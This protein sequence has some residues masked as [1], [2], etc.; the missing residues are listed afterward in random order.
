MVT[1]V[2]CVRSGSAAFK[3]CPKC[4]FFHNPVLVVKRQAVR[5]SEYDMISSIKMCKI[6][7]KI[8]PNKLYKYIILYN[9]IDVILFF[10]SYNEE[11][12]FTSK[13][14]SFN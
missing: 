10:L 6:M 8:R 1:S 12:T 2:V 13:G 11:F 5:S 7:R 14:S 3:F 4:R 9:I